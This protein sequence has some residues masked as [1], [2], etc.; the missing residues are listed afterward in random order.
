MEIQRLAADDIPLARALNALFAVEFEDPRSYAARLPEDAYL[1]EVLAREN[2]IALVAV[3]AGRVVGGAVA[4]ELD[5]L[6]QARREHYL[7]DLAVAKDYRR[8]GIATALIR[9]LQE[10]ARQRGAWVVYVQADRGDDPAIALYEKL[11]L[12][13]E[14]LHFDLPL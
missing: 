7:Y 6:E 2:I 3:E 4:Y 10:V 11:G 9:R 8:R 12:R 5:K 1:R 13:E 14:V